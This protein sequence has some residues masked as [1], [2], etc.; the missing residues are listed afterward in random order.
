MTVPMS[1]SRAENSDMIKDRKQKSDITQFARTTL[2]IM[3]AIIIQ[4]MN[5]CRLEILYVEGLY[6]NG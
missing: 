3:V 2:V 1:P 5:A 4:T 6:I